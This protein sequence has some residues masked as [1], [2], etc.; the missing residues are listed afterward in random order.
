MSKGAAIR[1]LWMMAQTDDTKID[2]DGGG[3]EIVV[4]VVARV[5]SA[6][7]ALECGNRRTTDH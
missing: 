3:D 2:H 4:E 6:T 1:V 7:V 5:T